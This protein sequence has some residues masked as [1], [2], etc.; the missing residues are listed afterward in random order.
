MTH[1]TFRRSLRGLSVLMLGAASLVACAAYPESTEVSAESAAL[2]TGTGL[3]ADYFSNQSLTAPAAL[4]RTDATVNFNWGTGSPGSSL[5]SDHFSVRW[6]GQVEA[7]YSQT[8]TFT[9]SSDDGIRLWVN[10]QQ[11][12]NNW[13]DHG[14]TAEQRQNRADRRPTVRHPTRVL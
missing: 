5:P 14:R 3:H 8:Y 7:L 1:P 6:T 12:I 10:G 4:S 9:T 13:T 2:S 11:I